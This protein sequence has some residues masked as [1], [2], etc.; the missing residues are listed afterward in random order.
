MRNRA[1]AREQ[2]LLVRSGDIGWTL[3]APLGI[4]LYWQFGGKGW[5]IYAFVTGVIAGLRT[6]V[7]NVGGER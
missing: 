5:L 6:I 3:G 1:E 7:R 2:D 4:A